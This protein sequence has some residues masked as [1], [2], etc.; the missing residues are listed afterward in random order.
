[1]KRFINFLFLIIISL[2]LVSCNQNNHQEPVNHHEELKDT[3]I[4]VKS[5][6]YNEDLINKTH[7]EARLYDELFTEDPNMYKKDLAKIAFL[8]AASCQSDRYDDTKSSLQI[9]PAFISAGF[10]DYEIC[11]DY[12]QIPTPKTLGYAIGFKRM[13]YYN[14][15][16]L[17]VRGISYQNEWMNNLDFGLEGEHQGISSWGIVLKNKLA[18]YI[19]DNNLSD[20]RVLVTGYSRGGMI[21]AQVGYQ[22]DINPDKELN[23]QNA[24]IYTFN[25]PGAFVVSNDKL[26]DN[27]INVI[28]SHEIVHMFFGNKL[29]FN[30]IGQEIDVYDEKYLKIK[31]FEE[32]TFELNAGGIKIITKDNSID[33]EDFVERFVTD[34]SLGSSEPRKFY[35]DYLEKPLGILL[36][37]IW[38]HYFELDKIKENVISDMGKAVVAIL[39][40]GNTL[41]KYMKD[42]LAKS[43]IDFDEAKLEPFIADLDAYLK[44]A[45]NEKYMTSLI[46]DI[47]TIFYNI[48]YVV[49]GH[50]QNNFYFYLFEVNS[51]EN[52]A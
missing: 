45:I 15:V 30:N 46:N 44:K 11:D 43:E 6:Y 8:F 22:I 17:V 31:D 40:G 42:V 13:K 49:T 52:N 1:M 3:N 50:A 37:F 19:K 14:L 27:I 18:E 7:V 23:S 28:N 26:Y 4:L 25:A 21:A 39:S 5:D 33:K 12:N 48:D 20:I 9:E 38:Q 2:G 51:N 34:L 16:L 10:D 41:K 35:Y 36:N 24:Y 32:V 29:G 47:I